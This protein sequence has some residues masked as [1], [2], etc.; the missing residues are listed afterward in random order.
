M[1]IFKHT[2]SLKHISTFYIDAAYPKCGGIC[3]P[4]ERADSLVD[5]CREETLLVVE[6]SASLARSQGLTHIRTCATVLFIYYAST[7]MYKLV[8]Y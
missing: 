3:I 8:T 5:I 2:L 1:N 4:V 7:F 6:S